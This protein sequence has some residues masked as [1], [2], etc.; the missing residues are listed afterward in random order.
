MRP[1]LLEVSI[2]YRKN[3]RLTERLGSLS[4]MA[5]SGET[6]RSQDRL[7]RGRTNVAKLTA[8]VPKKYLC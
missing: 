8:A 3:L 6:V 1:M 4:F 2:D 5:S 7:V